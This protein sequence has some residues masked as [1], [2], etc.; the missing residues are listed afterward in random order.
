MAAELKPWQ[1]QNYYEILEVGLKAAE[2]EI[3]IAYDTLKT[4]YSPSTPGMTLLF[5]PEE[6][7]KIHDKVEEAYRVLSDPRRQR[8]YDL[9]IRGEGEM[10]AVP[11]PAPLVTHRVLSPKQIAEALGGDEVH[12]SGKSLGKIRRYLSLEIDDVA[13]EIKVSKHNIEAIEEEDIDALPA[14]V[15]LKGFLRVYAKALGL[16]P[17]QVTDEY[18]A[19]ITE[20]GYKRE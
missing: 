13:V 18:L 17:K 7:K 20:K 9:M 4:I 1:E 11:A 2:E 3:R 12:W 14:A 16:D 10:T 6:V 15:Y 19:R 8:E 5:T